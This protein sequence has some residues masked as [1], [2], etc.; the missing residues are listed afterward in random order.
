MDATLEKYTSYKEGLTQAIGVTDI[1]L[2][3]FRSARTQISINKDNATAGSV[4]VQ[5]KYHPSASWETLLDDSGN[6]RSISMTTPLTF[7]IEN[8]L[9]HSLRFT[10]SGV[11]GNYSVYCYQDPR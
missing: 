10:P 7:I 6:P 3:G 4:T 9:L 11:V 8:D 2:K 1:I 5:V